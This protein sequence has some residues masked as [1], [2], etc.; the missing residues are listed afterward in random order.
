[1][2]SGKHWHCTGL[3]VHARQPG[4]GRIASSGRYFRFA[5]H[6]DPR[7]IGS[8][9]MSAGGDQILYVGYELVSFFFFFFFLFFLDARCTSRIT[10]IECGD[11]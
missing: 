11:M 2:V 10:K 7:L 4:T 8:Y 5:H 9:L 3:V 1:M 6:I